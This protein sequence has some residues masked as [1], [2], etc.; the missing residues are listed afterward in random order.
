MNTSTKTLP[1]GAAFFDVV[2]TLEARCSAESIVEIPKLGLSTP[3]CF[4]SLGDVLSLLYA[5]ASCFHGC[6]GGD[7][8]YHRIT[9]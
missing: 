7:H 6:L 9:A 2:A 5:E 1:R 8:F 4:D 3:V